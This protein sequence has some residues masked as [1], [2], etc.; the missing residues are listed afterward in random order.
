MA[1]FVGAV[2]IGAKQSNG[3]R[4]NVF[5]FLERHL[6]HYSVEEG[7]QIQYEGDDLYMKAYFLTYESA[8]QL[9][10]ALNA[11]EI[12]KDLANLRG[13]T[14]DPLTPTQIPRPTD[15]RRIY[16]QQY[17]PQDSES[18]C[19]TLAHL[20]SYRLSVPVTE[21]A[22]PNT[23]LVR[24]Q[25]IDKLIPHL[26]HYKCHLKDKARFKGLQSNENNMVAASWAFHQQLDG[27][28]VK[29]GIPLVAISI[30]SA[31]NH[32]VASHDN[33]YPV[34][35]SIEFFYPDLAASFAAVDG[36]RKGMDD[37]TWETLVYVQDKILFVEC[38]QWKY[39]ETKQQWQNHR[40]FLEQE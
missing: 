9:Q 18:S 11:W 5:K 20:H 32:W 2:V 16:L 40:A 6:G 29:E 8:C 23:P 28:N 10:N 26:N 39:L 21:P 35:L 12:H 36:A 25:S 17:Q 31:S 19:Q 24:F 33:R 4:G 22:E 37:S 34:T 1:F 3:A 27:L 38:V 13:V 15:L 7:I 14:L 30:K